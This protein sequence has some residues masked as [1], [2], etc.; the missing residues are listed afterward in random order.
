M[1]ISQ[2]DEIRK[3]IDW[4]W[5]WRDSATIAVQVKLMKKAQSLGNIFVACYEN[6]R[7]KAQNPYCPLLKA[8][9]TGCNGEVV[10][11]EKALQRNFIH[12]KL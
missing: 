11:S 5:F 8:N 3:K 12:E 9:L 4:Q 2:I 10:T 6:Y 1:D 7:L